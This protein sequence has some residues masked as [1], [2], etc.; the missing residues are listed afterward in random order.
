MNYLDA[1][2]Q[3]ALDVCS[4]ATTYTLNQ[5]GIEKILS[6]H[7]PVKLGSMYTKASKYIIRCRALGGRRD[8]NLKNSSSAGEFYK[9]SI[10]GM[11]KDLPLYN[12]RNEEL[13]VENLR[14]ELDFTYSPIALKNRCPCDSSSLVIGSDHTNNS[15][16]RVV[17][18][19]EFRE[20]YDE[21]KYEAFGDVSYCQIHSLVDMVRE[22]Y[23]ET[24]KQ[25]LIVE[26]GPG[27]GFW[28]NRVG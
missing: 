16:L 12:G 11:V 28:I 26:L 1:L 17:K 20:F 5:A 21:I 18:M 14:D 2:K 8:K 3:F 24:G 10:L 22:C 23:G 6:Y 19:N 9:N 25:I 13:D 27:I 15:Q 4:S 7:H